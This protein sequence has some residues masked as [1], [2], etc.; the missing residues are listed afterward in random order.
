MHWSFYT[1][2]ALC[3]LV[4]STRGLQR[5]KEASS[6]PSAPNAN[7]VLCSEIH[8]GHDS[9]VQPPPQDD[10]VVDTAS[11]QETAVEEP[12]HVSPEDTPPPL[13]AIMPPSL[14]QSLQESLSWVQRATPLARATA[15]WK[16]RR[17][18]NPA[19]PTTLEESR[20]EQFHQDDVQELQA[21]PVHESLLQQQQL[22]Q[23]QEKKQ[24]QR[25]W[26][27]YPFNPEEHFQEELAKQQQQRE[28]Q[29]QAQQQQAQAQQPQQTRSSHHVSSPTQMIATGVVSC[30]GPLALVSPVTV[31]A[32]AT[33]AVL[34]RFQQPLSKLG[35]TTKHTMCRVIQDVHCRYVTHRT[36]VRRRLL[37]ASQEQESTIAALE[38]W[39]PQETTIMTTAT[40]YSNKRTPPSP[41]FGKTMLALLTETTLVGLVWELLLQVL[42]GYTIIFMALVTLFLPWMG[43]VG[44][45]MTYVHVNGFNRWAQ[46]TLAVACGYASTVVMNEQEE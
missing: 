19:R 31:A 9:C 12:Q 1:I 23:P 17:L 2:L 21:H 42:G 20:D 28:E 35:V 34:Y 18:H 15:E 46:V 6:A 11:Q 3:C 26:S 36:A 27:R 24:Q 29:V 10:S 4:G 8:Q 38:E 5:P 32:T 7:D 16:N 39:P 30:R 13:K 14:R 33:A 45:W 44:A 40:Q 41:L 25:W 22:H 37:Q 43:T